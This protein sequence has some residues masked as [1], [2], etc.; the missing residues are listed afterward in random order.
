MVRLGF[1]RAAKRENHPNGSAQAKSLKDLRVK[2]AGAGESQSGPQDLGL[3]H[4]F[5]RVAQ[6]GMSYLMAQNH[7]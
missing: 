3:T 6:Q 4:S 5:A 1:L 2:A 7:G